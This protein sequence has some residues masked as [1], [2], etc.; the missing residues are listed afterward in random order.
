[1]MPL[2]GVTKQWNSMICCNFLAKTSVKTHFHKRS[3]RLHLLKKEQDF[4][5]E[6]ETRELCVFVRVCAASSAQPLCGIYF[7][8]KACFCLA[9]E[10]RYYPPSYTKLLH[11][12]QFIF[13]MISQKSIRSCKDK[14]EIAAANW[15]GLGGTP[16]IMLCGRV[17]LGLSVGLPSKSSCINKISR[18]SMNEFTAGSAVITHV[19][20]LCED[21]GGD[22]W[23]N[24]ILRRCVCLVARRGSGCG[25]WPN[26]DAALCHEWKQ[27]GVP[28][29]KNLR[30][31]SCECLNLWVPRGLSTVQKI[32]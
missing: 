9:A 32:V 3:R 16:L 10:R 26:E 18:W 29:L 17:G 22:K 5:T 7:H 25:G 15:C 20:G 8:A 21:S 24:H 30:L 23:G 11:T 14:Y 6:K 31:C 27:L 2:C 19:S 4:S 28:A 12:W 1:M 13:C